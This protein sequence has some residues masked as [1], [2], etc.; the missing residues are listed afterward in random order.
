MG[1]VWVFAPI[2]S[3]WEITKLSMEAANTMTTLARIAGSEQG[4]EHPA[5]RLEGG[6]AEVH[7]GLLVFLSD[8][9]QARPD[10][11][12]GIGHHEHRQAP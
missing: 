6:G 4:Q 8:R 7:R 12:H 10:D 2:D 1:T 9:E 3:C 5:E 11:D